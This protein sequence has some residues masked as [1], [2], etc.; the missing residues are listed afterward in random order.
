MKFLVDRNVIAEA[1]KEQR[2]QNPACI[3]WLKANSSELYTSP[4][5]LGEKEKG[6]ELMAEGRKEKALR[7]WFEQF[8]RD[9]EYSV[10]PIDLKVGLKWGQ[11]EAAAKRQGITKSVEDHLLAATALVHGMTVV[12]ENTKDF[13]HT[14][15]KVLNPFTSP[16]PLSSP[17]LNEPGVCLVSVQKQVPSRRRNSNILKGAP[18]PGP[19]PVR[20]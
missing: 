14:G 12:T 3:R 17:P 11:I 8:L 16:P 19:L 13:I 20:S 7:V 5:V 2:E 1:E 9:C 6:I 4:I 15:A 18:L 10:I